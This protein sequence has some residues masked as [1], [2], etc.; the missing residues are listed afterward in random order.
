MTMKLGKKP[1]TYDARDLQFADYLVTTKIPN[2]TDKRVFGHEVNVAQWGMLGNGPD[3]TVEP[4]FEGAGDCVLAGAGHETMLW[5]TERGGASVPITGKES[6][7]DYSAVT[8][9]VVGDDSTDQGTEVRAALVYRQQTGVLDATGARHKIGAFAAI[10]PGHWEHVLQALY[11]FGVVGIGIEFPG[12][13][14]DQFD[15][16]QMWRV[17]PGASIEG[18]HYIPLVA[19]RG[20]TKLVTWAQ[21]IGMTKAFFEKYCDEAW[22]ILS[23][24]HLTGAAGTSPEGFDMSALR[25]DLAKVS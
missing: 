8:G 5:T 24:E 17:V 21:E 15:R 13:A 9:Y 1:A 19:R 7:S 22:A 14:M 23:S 25:A 11:L 20:V 12:S 3:D 6:I 4:G 2:I 18:G 16:G 10:E